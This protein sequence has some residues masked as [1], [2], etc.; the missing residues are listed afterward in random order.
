MTERCQPAPTQQLLPSL[1]TRGMPTTKPKPSDSLVCDYL[2][3]SWEVNMRLS[4][5]EAQIDKRYSKWT[6]AKVNRLVREMS[7]MGVKTDRIKL[8]RGTWNMM[9]I[10]APTINKLPACV[11]LKHPLST[12]TT[13]RIAQEFANKGRGYIHHITILAGVKCLTSEILYRLCEGAAKRENEYIIVPP[14][15]LVLTK[16]SRHNIHWLAC[17]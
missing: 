9:P 14:A 12:S 10:I 6:P 16:Q 2:Q 8:Y 7:S 15:K 3:S 11:E 17:V 5:L 13:K 1:F 4:G